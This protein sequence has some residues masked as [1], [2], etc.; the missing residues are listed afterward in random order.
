MKLLQEQEAKENN[1]QN[2][3]K[4]DIAIKSK[5]KCMICGRFLFEAPRC[6]GHGSSGGGGA[7]GE[8][9]AKDA[10]ASLGASSASSGITSFQPEGSVS[11]RQDGVARSKILV[12]SQ[13]FSIDLSV[14]AKLLS[15]DTLL[16]KNDRENGEFSVGIDRNKWCVLSQN[17]K[18][19]LQ[20]FIQLIRQEF[21]EFKEKLDPADKG[22]CLCTIENDP[23]NNKFILSLNIK[24]LD[25][26]L[27]LY[28]KFIQQLT[29]TIK[30]LEIE[31]YGSAIDLITTLLQDESKVSSN[32]KEQ[33]K[34][35]FISHLLDTEKPDSLDVKQ[36]IGSIKARKITPLLTKPKP[37]GLD[38]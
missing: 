7:T 15:N 13:S 27:K 38:I 19:E 11:F 28:D 5:P 22:K 10:V 23:K 30:P 25:P 9:A 20:K 21:N 14:I 29:N 8:G 1:K 32:S 4:K 12:P 31:K 35:Q 6:S 2:E 16:I 36:N 18:D 3:I 33:V 26:S 17:E 37:R 34:S 24:I